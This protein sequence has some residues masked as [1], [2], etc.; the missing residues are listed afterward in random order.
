[1]K[2]GRRGTLI[3]FGEASKEPPVLDY[4]SF[5]KGPASGTIR[6]F[7]Y[8]DSDISDGRDLATLVRLVKAGQLHPEIG[9]AADW[10]ETAAAIHSLRER[11]VRG[12]AILT[13]AV[14]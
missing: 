5:W 13:I 2:L 7:D 14:T 6:H 1:M 4:F 12:N 8:T 11:G 3:W 10:S 9:Y